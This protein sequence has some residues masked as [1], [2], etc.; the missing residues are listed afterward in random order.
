MRKRSHFFSVIMPVYNS[1]P[2]LSKSL[3]SIISQSF[4]DFELV[5]INDG[6]TDNS[7]D[8]INSV[9]PKPDYIEK[10][11]ANDLSGLLYTY[12]SFK[13]SIIVINHK[14]NYGVV[15]ARDTGISCSTGS[16]IT[17]IDSDDYFD[18]NRLDI[19]Y[20][21]I[22]KNKPDVLITGYIHETNISEIKNE[23]LKPGLFNN[24]FF[25]TKPQIIAYKKGK[26]LISPNLWNK[27][28]RRDLMEQSIE[29]IPDW[30][31]IGDDNPRT[32]GALL[33]ANSLMI[34][35][36][37]S[38]HYVQRKNQL[39]SKFYPNYWETRMFIF[40]YL[41]SISDNIVL[42]DN[43][44]REI[45]N[46]IMNNICCRSATAIILEA[47][48]PFN[49]YIEKINRIKEICNDKKIISLLNSELIFRQE[50]YDRFLL[51]LMK[52]KMYRILLFI[53][54]IRNFLK[55]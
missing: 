19:I 37:H 6:S 24:G 23:G 31:V 39:T 4:Q 13:F 8:I 7:L 54:M 15:K 50:T 34:I 11:C 25:D 17:W 3:N 26:R 22:K 36:D 49:S 41:E 12:E 38:Y 2:F 14:K 33:L 29:R 43:I 5:I 28:F 16:Y 51:S 30:L 21:N 55:L 47:K 35:D 10:K 42:P 45:K 9:I 46:E 40:D 20:Q 48:N 52:R 32:Y 1:E 53:G 44:K 18:C 27:V